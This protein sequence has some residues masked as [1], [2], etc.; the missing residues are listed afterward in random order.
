MKILVAPDSFKDALPA[1]QVCEA[2]RRGVQRALPDADVKLFPLADGGEGTVEVLAWHLSGQVVKTIVHDPLMRPVQAQYF[3]A[4][5]VA[6]VEI[7][8]IEMAQASGLQLLLEEERNPLITSTFG[9]GEL[10]L[11]AQ[12][13]GA[14]NC[15]FAVGGSATNDAGMGMAAAL[16][17]RF[18]DENGANLAPIGENLLRVTKVLPPN[19]KLAIANPTLLADVTNPLFGPNGAAYI[20]APQK[21]ADAAAVEA[22]DT[23]LRHFAGIVERTVGNDFSQVPGAGAAGG[24]GFGAMAFLGASMQSGALTILELVGFEQ[25]A[26]DCD[27]VI[28]GEGKLDGQTQQGKLVAAVSQK[29]GAVGVP[30][31]AICGAV[32]ATPAEVTAMGLSGVFELRRQGETLSDSIA[33]TDIALEEMA[34]NVLKTIQL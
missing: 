30:V 29:A 1:L 13:N 18:L 6:G 28:T 7:A 22:L 2:I 14:K 27:L 19:L 31:M 5:D 8:F 4:K 17:W 21:G 33:R 24:L 16:G 26:S 12:E 11:S 23:G 15:Y 20:F 34:Y 25:V 3:L 32:E 9:A 10:L